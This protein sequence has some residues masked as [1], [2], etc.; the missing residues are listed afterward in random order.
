MIYEIVD[1]SDDEQYF[2]L[3]YFTNKDE[4]IQDFNDCNEPED[5]GSSCGNEYEAGFEL[6]EHKEGWGSYYKVIKRVKFVSALNK[7]KDDFIWEKQL[8]NCIVD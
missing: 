1:S 8:K 5:F 7:E 4:A 6:R 2:S 3:G